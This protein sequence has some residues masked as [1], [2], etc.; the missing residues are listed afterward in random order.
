MVE[1]KGVFE[2]AIRVRDLEKSEAFYCEVLG[3]QSGLREEDRRWHFLWAGD[4]GG[5]VVLQEDRGDW[6]LQHFAF[7]V[8][9]DELDKAIANLRERGV[10]V[11]D[12]VTHDWMPARSAY[13]VDPDGNQL[14]FC[15]PLG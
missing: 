4:R 14:E 2:I 6:P 13:F 9:P 12:P 5:M 11:S 8:P 10:T 15:A 3:L 1:I 7:S